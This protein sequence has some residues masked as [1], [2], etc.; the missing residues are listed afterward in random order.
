VLPALALFLAGPAVA[1]Q[2]TGPARFVGE[3]EGVLVAGPQQLPII[4]HVTEADGGGGLAATMDSPAQNAF[5]LPMDAVTV[6]GDSVSMTLT[7]AQARYDGVLTEDGSTLEGTWTQGPASLELVLE[8]GGGDGDGGAASGDAGPA[9]G[10]IPDPSERP[11]TP[12]PP[13][14][15]ASR[16]VS[17]DGAGDFSLAGTLTVPRGDGPHPGVILVSGSGPQDRDETLL[18]HKPF[19]VLADHLTRAGIAVLRYDD[20]GVA[21]S[22]GVFATA[23]SDD[24]ARDAEAALSWLASRPEVDGD[25][26]G[27]VG[28]SEGGLIAPLVASRS[29]LPAFL[30][31]LA[32]PGMSGAEIILDQTAAGAR[33]QGVDE[34]YI[35]ESLAVTRALFEI[36]AREPDAEAA[37]AEMAALL[38]ARMADVAAE[39]R[40]MAG[41]QEGGEEAWIA[42]QVERVNTPWFRYFLGYDPVPALEAVRV[43]VLAVNGELDVQVTPEANLAAIAAALERAG[44]PDV[45]VRELPGLNHL[46]QEAETGS[47][48][49]YAAIDQTMS[50]RLLEL[51]ADWIVA[52]VG[53]AP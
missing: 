14:P 17:F 20:R 25:R 40:A 39:T 26:V 19:A 34:A 48:A 49:E 29:E 44:N 27:I 24:L 2:E 11:Q 53:G 31:L 3:W 41:I 1:A 33:V 4:F 21:A 8:R 15:Y 5:G 9:G 30:V 36:A 46:F 7:A 43:P 47:P 12:K 13:H 6:S 35:E 51:V 42:S 45:T 22:G 10:G 28:H 18:G 23:T 16:D 38:R 52:R 37:A 32:G 50:P